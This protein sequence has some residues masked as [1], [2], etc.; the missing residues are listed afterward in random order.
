MIE[1]S[2]EEDEVQLDF[3][4]ALKNRFIVN[5]AYR[6]EGNNKYYGRCLIFES[7]KEVSIHNNS[8]CYYNSKGKLLYKEFIAKTRIEENKVPNSHF[9]L[10]DDL[11][12]VSRANAHQISYREPDYNI[13]YFSQVFDINLAPLQFAAGLQ[14]G[15]IILVKNLTG[16]FKVLNFSPV[17]EYLVS[18]DNMRILL[19]LRESIIILDNPFEA[20]Y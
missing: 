12:A 5:T 18:E 11:E 8:N 14:N 9:F 10:N 16:E 6:D 15:G 13:Y 2:L 1:F 19:F 17:V 3:P 4:L 7:G 20:D